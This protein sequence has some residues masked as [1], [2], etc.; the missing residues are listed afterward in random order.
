VSSTAAGLQPE[1]KDSPEASTRIFLL[2]D[3]PRALTS[4]DAAPGSPV[5]FEGPSPRECPRDHA[6]ESSEL[7]GSRTAA[8]E[9]RLARGEHHGT[10]LGASRQER[11]IGHTAKRDAERAVE[12]TA[13]CW[14]CPQASPRRRGRH[15]ESE[16]R[17]A[18]RCRRPPPC[19]AGCMAEWVAHRR[20]DRQSYE[21]ATAKRAK[22]ASRQSAVEQAV[23]RRASEQAR[24][25]RAVRHAG[26]H[27]SWYNEDGYPAPCR[28]S[29]LRGLPG[30]P[31]RV[32]IE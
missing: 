7:Y 32:P 20:A 5:E 26:K 12:R 2:G 19:V 10:L 15:R 1:R 22:E 8:R 11:A 24:A 4:S 31:W 25:E 28:A 30:T 6:E 18:L 9:K 23:A 13:E 17:M 3:Q 14:A 16:S 29:Q 21:R 27:G